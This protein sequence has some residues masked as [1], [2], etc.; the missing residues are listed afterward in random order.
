MLKFHNNLLLL[1][2][3]ALALLLLLSSLLFISTLH[4]ISIAI[5]IKIMKLRTVGK[6]YCKS[7]KIIKNSYEWHKKIFPKEWN[8]K[9]ER[10]VQLI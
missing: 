5:N 7:Y 8:K 3:L 10:N 1:S 6:R 2:S 4:D 9:V